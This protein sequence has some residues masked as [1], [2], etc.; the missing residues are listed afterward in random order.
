MFGASFF[1]TVYFQSMNGISATKSGFDILPLML[2]TVV[3][4][5]S[6]AGG[7]LMT[8]WDIIP[9]FL[10][11]APSYSLSALGSSP[12]TH[13]PFSIWFGYQILPGAGV[14]VGSQF[15]L[16]AVQTVLSLADLPVA[17]ALV[18]FP[19]RC[20]LHP[21]WANSLHNGLEHTSSLRTWIPYSC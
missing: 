19:R 18:V 17:S 21:S 15:P 4:A 16:I 11:R 12:H 9:H 7:D 13:M 6:M 2:S 5:S 1:L 20:T 8:G 14:G 10:S 3:R